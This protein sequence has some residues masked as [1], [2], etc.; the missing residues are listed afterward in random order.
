MSNSLDMYVYV[1]ILCT[2][3]EQAVTVEE[4][5]MAMTFIANFGYG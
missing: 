1:Y 3:D 4:R 2:R 5:M